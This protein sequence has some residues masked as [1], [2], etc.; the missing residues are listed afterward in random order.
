MNREEYN[1]IKDLNYREYCKYLQ[2]KYG[3]P[4]MNY[5]T[6][7]GNRYSKNNRAA[8]DGLMIHHLYEDH[9]I[10][11]S[12][13]GRALKRP[14]EW[15]RKENLLY[16]DCLERLYLHYLICINPSDYA[17]ENNIQ[18]GLNDIIM[19]LVPKLNDAYSG[20]LPTVDFRKRQ[21]DLIIE[22]KDVYLEIVKL[23]KERYVGRIPHFMNI[24]LFTSYN[25]RYRVW[26]R[27]YN[28]ELFDEIAKL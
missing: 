15:Q 16:C 9:D 22:D 13:R 26:K 7:K 12:E 28:Q 5:M 24:Y 11:L 17:K 23:I 1:R 21:R 19:E 3:L 20:Y 8:D 27:E 25:E 14:Y 4:P 6:E 2:D 10:K 18:V